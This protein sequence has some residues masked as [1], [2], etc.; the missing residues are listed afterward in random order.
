MR[1]CD[2]TRGCGPTHIVGCGRYA[3]Y[4]LVV[5]GQKERIQD[6]DLEGAF[7]IHVPDQLLLV[8]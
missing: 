4:D 5:W 1:A 2:G 8:V 7:R 3:E 6:G